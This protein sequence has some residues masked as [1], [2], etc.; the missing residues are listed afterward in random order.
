MSSYDI[1][2]L[3]LRIE[4]Y[5]W[6]NDWFCHTAKILIITL[7]LWKNF[8]SLNRINKNK[9]SRHYQTNHWSLYHSKHLKH[10]HVLVSVFKE[11]EVREGRCGFSYHL[12]QITASAQNATNKL[13]IS[14]KEIRWLQR[15]SVYIQSDDNS[16]ILDFRGKIYFVR[17]KINATKSVGKLQNKSFT[18]TN[19]SG[20]ICWWN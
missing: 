8:K 5:N 9:R 4:I 12:E 3:S 13:W 16:Y 7:E 10:I 17:S 14:R 20:L 19:I 6:Q 1:C 11:A 15:N 18:I 2:S